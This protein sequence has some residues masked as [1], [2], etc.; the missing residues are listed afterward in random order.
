MSGGGGYNLKPF[1]CRVE[2]TKKAHYNPKLW[3]D[4]KEVDYIWNNTVDTAAARAYIDTK[5]VPTLETKIQMKWR[6]TAHHSMYENSIYSYNGSGQFNV[7]QETVYDA[8]GNVNWQMGG[9]TASRRFYTSVGA[10]KFNTV[11]DL[12]GNKNGM[13]IIISGSPTAEWNG[14]F[15]VPFSSPATSMTLKSPLRFPRTST[16]TSNN[17][18]ET[19]YFYG[20]VWESD[21]LKHFYI[22]AVNCLDK[23]GVLDIVGDRFHTCPTAYKFTAGA[24]TKDCYWTADK[25]P[26]PKQLDREI[27]I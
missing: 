11:F 15:I 4:F 13:D 12:I 19:I 16:S 27:N 25:R 22:P 23:V 9:R 1:L 6:R 14:H 7:S 18:E 17:S 24:D 26:Y 10:S 5:Y 21:V 2:E 3:T 8:G 20:R